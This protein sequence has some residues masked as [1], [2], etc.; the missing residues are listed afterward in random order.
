VLGQQ[1]VQFQAAAALVVF[2][3]HTSATLK[4]KLEQ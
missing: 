3:S 1:R 2:I 4:D